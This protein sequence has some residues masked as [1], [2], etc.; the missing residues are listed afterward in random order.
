M[1]GP[2]LRMD[3]V[4]RKHKDT[5]IDA[6]L[7]LQHLKWTI[8]S[9]LY[10]LSLVK[11]R[12]IEL[13]FLFPYRRDSSDSSYNGNHELRLCHRLRTFQNNSMRLDPATVSPLRKVI[14]SEEAKRKWR[15]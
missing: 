11:V 10:E 1:E 2:F 14:Q 5:S 6:Q 15:L 9:T 12:I 13:P 3:S 8:T 4:L 7:K